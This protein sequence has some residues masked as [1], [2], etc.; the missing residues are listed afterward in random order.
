MC[1]Y[2]R[3]SLEF[4]SAAITDG[5]FVCCSSDGLDDDAALRNWLQ[6]VGADAF[7]LDGTVEGSTEPNFECDVWQYT[8]TGKVDGISGNVDV[9]IITGTGKTLEWFLGGDDV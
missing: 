1:P 2:S 3:I 9:N 6:S 8:S 7:V 4:D 5:T